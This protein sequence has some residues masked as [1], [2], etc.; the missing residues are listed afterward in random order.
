M[1]FHSLYRSYGMVL[2][3][4][5]SAILSTMLHT[6]TSLTLVISFSCSSAELAQSTFAAIKKQNIQLDL[7]I[8]HY[9]KTKRYIYYSRFTLIFFF[10]FAT[11]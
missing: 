2:H 5:T 4:K 7:S 8:T 11:E 1:H 6:V 3:L 9:S 10:F